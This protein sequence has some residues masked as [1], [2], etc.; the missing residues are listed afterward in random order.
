MS[1]RI[2]SSAPSDHENRD[3]PQHDPPV[4]QFA[5][6]PLSAEESEFHD[7]VFGK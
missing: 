3:Q 6:L 5:G 1:E 4:L 2:A 7:Y